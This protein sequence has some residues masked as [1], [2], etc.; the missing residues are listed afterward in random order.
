[1]SNIIAFAIVVI[2]LASQT[3]FILIVR[4]FALITI[5]GHL[6]LFLAIV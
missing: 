2:N 5:A 6:E 1:M 4:M 3:Y